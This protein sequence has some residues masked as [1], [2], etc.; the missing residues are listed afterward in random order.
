MP[1]TRSQQRAREGLVSLD[2]DALRNVLSFL[3]VAD[4]RRGAGVTSKALHQAVTSKQLTRARAMA[5]YVL[6]GDTHGVVHALATAMGTRRWPTKV[7]LDVG[8]GLNTEVTFDALVPPASLGVTVSYL[9]THG[10]W[11]PG[12]DDEILAFIQSGLVDQDK[13]KGISCP[14]GCRVLDGSYIGYELP[15]KLQISRFRFAV[16]DCGHRDFRDWTFEAFDDERAEWRGL[17]LCERSPWAEEP[18]VSPDGENFEAVILPVEADFA[19]TRFRIRL[20]ESEPD[21]DRG[22]GPGP[23]PDYRCIHVRGL[24]IFGTVLPP[25]QV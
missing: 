10:V 2:D 5:P 20:L 15:F 6:R 8:H 18:H 1:R 14:A 19:S 12:S 16:A 9:G 24:E 4:G 3:S 13:Y 7:L 21:P 25:W 23:H 22:W 17:Y 11:D